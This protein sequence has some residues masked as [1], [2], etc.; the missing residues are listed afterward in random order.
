MG[1]RE[2]K[3]ELLKSEYLCIF[4]TG[5]VS[6]CWYQRL[7]RLQ[8]RIDCF[9]DNNPKYWGM[10]IVDRIK[11]ISPKELYDKGGNVLCVLCVGEKY[12]NEIQDQLNREH[13][14][15]I[16]L[17]CDSFFLE[18]ILG[19]KIPVSQSLV[20]RKTYLTNISKAEK[21]AVYT[22][23][24]GDYDSLKQ[25]LVV[26]TQCDYYC[27]SDVKPDN[28]GVF[29]WID[30]K[31]ILPH[32]LKGNKLKNRYCKFLPHLLFKQHNYSIYL[33]GSILIKDRL[34]HILRKLGDIGIGVYGHPDCADTY[35]EVL[36]LCEITGN[37]F[38][39]ELIA[40]QLKEYNMEGFPYGLGFTENSVLVRNHGNIYCKKI[41]EM[42]WNEFLRFPTR[43]QL[44]FIYVL[45]KS[46][47][48]LEDITVLGSTWRNIQEFEYLGHNSQKAYPKW[49]F[50]KNL[51]R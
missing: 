41:M 26:D 19:M 31:S 1:W 32:D 15:Y 17:E 10:E 46:G 49:H 21:T 50:A 51:D 39:L 20:K 28:L 13:I 4:G 7:Q 33:D 29:Q 48:R 11:C 45:W 2:K 25:P 43:D 24:F 8:I 22:A 5:Q 6:E 18:D 40:K 12:R 42:W 16:I 14:R 35:E 38:D 9:C 30:A 37:F 27:I 44:S 47:Y 34:W 3:D 23:I 36:R